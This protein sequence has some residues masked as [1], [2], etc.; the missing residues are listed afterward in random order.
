MVGAKISLVASEP[1][2][3]LN[4]YAFL[5]TALPS[6]PPYLYFLASKKENLKSNLLLYSITRLTT[7]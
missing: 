5:L 2:F 3:S 7:C 6:H 1:S 4:P